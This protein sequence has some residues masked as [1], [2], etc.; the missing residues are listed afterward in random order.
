MPQT[1]RLLSQAVNT[2]PEL[3]VNLQAAY[4]LAQGRPT[5]P[6]APLAAVG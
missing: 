2:T 4:D 3:W 6:V 5:A 1:A